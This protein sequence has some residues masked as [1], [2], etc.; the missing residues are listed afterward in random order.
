MDEAITKAVAELRP[1]DE[2]DAPHGAF[3]VIL[4]T[5]TSDR[6]G[7][8]VKAEEWQQPLPDHITFDVDHGMSVASTVGSG[9]PRLEADGTLRVTGTYAS[10]PKAQETRALVNEGHIRTVSVT[11]LRK[12]G[13]KG[14]GRPLTRELLNGTFCAVPVNPEARILLSKHI[15]TKAGARNSAT[16][17][18][19][20]QDA[21]DN[22]VAAG[23]MCATG[24]AMSEDGEDANPTELAQSLD[25][26]I[27]EAL[28][29]I[30]GID[31]TGLPEP[32]AQSLLLLQ[33]A[34]VLSDELLDAMGAPDPD[35]DTGTAAAAPK[36]AAPSA[37]DDET[38]AAELAVRARKVR[39][40]AG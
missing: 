19:H 4:S 30:E 33:A 37:A 32:V 14:S 6:E 5:P 16:D 40:L 13:Q 35:E 24:K 39:L 18:G 3:E 7:E 9:V 36:S 29:L 17:Q 25:A 21:H 8:S 26:T 15:E 2:S 22:L 20:I 31:V 28:A 12:G 38:A 27:D 34:D 23:A 1:A 10:T 11:F